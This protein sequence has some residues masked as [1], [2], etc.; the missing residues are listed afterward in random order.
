MRGSDDVRDC[1]EF[2]NVRLDGRGVALSM[3]IKIEAF[4]R[5]DAD[6]NVRTGGTTGANTVKMALIRNRCAQKKIHHKTSRESEQ[7][8]NGTLYLSYFTIPSRAVTVQVVE[9]ICE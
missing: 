6:K 3:I 2:K 8:R 1:G 7:R 4:T 9:C 5:T